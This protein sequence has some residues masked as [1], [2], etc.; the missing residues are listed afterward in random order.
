M[1]S[2]MMISGLV[3]ARYVICRKR[4]RR[5][6]SMLW[7]VAIIGMALRVMMGRHFLSDTI[8]A[9]LFVSLIAV[10]LRPL[11][12][13]RNVKDGSAPLIPAVR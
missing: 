11:L 9:A 12:A 5:V 10:L 3:L 13:P 1:I 8:F 6:L 7:V 2:A 4:R